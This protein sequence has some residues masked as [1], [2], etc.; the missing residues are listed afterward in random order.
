M[1]DLLLIEK[2]TQ[3]TSLWMAYNFVLAGYE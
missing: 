1:I 2:A 3:R